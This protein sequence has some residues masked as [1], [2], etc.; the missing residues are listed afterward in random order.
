MTA[1]IA[2]TPLT[3]F[4]TEPPAAE[5]SARA[6]QSADDESPGARLLGR[7]VGFGAT[8]LLVSGLIGLLLAEYLVLWHVLLAPL[9]AAVPGWLP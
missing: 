8:V 5:A 6:E 9:S 3:G 2:A 4:H 7:I 1:A